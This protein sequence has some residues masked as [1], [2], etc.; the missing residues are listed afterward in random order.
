MHKLI[1]L[2]EPPA[3]DPDFDER[4]PEFITRSAIIPGLRR[5]TTSRIVHKMFGNYSCQLIHELYFESAGALREALNSP[6]GIQAGKSLQRITGGRVTLLIAEHL[7][8][9]PARYAN[10]VQIHPQ[11]GEHSAPEQGS[12]P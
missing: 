12:T 10:R 1:I 4:W 9:D 5:E 2:I 7:E 3:D 6:I 8:D 11:Q